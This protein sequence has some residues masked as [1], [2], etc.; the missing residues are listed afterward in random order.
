VKYSKK[1]EVSMTAIAS[2]YA[3]DRCV[4]DQP[5]PSPVAT[6]GISGG[7]HYPFEVMPSVDAVRYV[8]CGECAALIE[9][10]AKGGETEVSYVGQNGWNRV[11]APSLERRL[12]T[13]LYG[14]LA[15]RPWGPL[16]KAILETVHRNVCAIHNAGTPSATLPEDM[17]RMFAPASVGPTRKAMLAIDMVEECRATTCLRTLLRQ[18]GYSGPP[19]II[20]GEESLF[21]PGLDLSR[22]SR[23][24][25]LQD[26]VDGT[27]E[28]EQGMAGWC[29]SMVVF[30]PS[31]RRIL[32]AV[33]G[34]PDRSLYFA[35][36][37]FV[38][39][40]RLTGDDLS[41]A[42]DVHPLNGPSGVSSLADSV[43]SFYGHKP[44]RLVKLAD[45]PRYRALLTRMGASTRARIRTQG[46]QPMM[47][48]LADRYGYRQVDAVFEMLGQAPH[49]VV[50]GLHIARLAGAALCDVDGGPVDLAEALLR[51]ATTT[52]R[53]TYV[54]AASKALAD[55]LLQSW[56]GVCPNEVRRPSAD[57]QRQP[58][59]K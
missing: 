1:V 49:D 18:S 14:L 55:E 8:D 59:F 52:S 33:V 47:M 27:D 34:L 19:P 31:E 57:S 4:S 15:A 36:D 32:A 51:P 30:L 28:V 54:L 25:V 23:P 13:T 12:K 3:G 45:D 24:I 38:G 10:F 16:Y 41:I 42:P 48:R 6:T 26:T 9:V 29:S 7:R 56:L 17:D 39:K 37:G 5:V 2:K 11:E 50:A 40:C 35:L 22:Q 21:D 43:V 20:R 44:S 53:L 58:S 46:G